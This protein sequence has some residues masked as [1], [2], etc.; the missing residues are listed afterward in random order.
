M[1][2]VHRHR[3]VLNLHMHLRLSD[4]RGIRSLRSPLRRRLEELEGVVAE[5]LVLE[6]YELRFPCWHSNQRLLMWRL[7]ELWSPRLHDGSIILRRIVIVIFRGWPLGES[8][9]S[10]CSDIWGSFPHHL[11]SGLR[12]P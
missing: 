2:H 10:S 1:G 11:S 6:R 5:G 3:H 7:R 9:F 8:A 12:R 4:R